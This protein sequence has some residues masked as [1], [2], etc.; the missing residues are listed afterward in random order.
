MAFPIIP[1]LNSAPGAGAPETLTLGELAANRSTAKLYLG[2]DTGVQEI[3]F[4]GS[5]GGTAISSF[6][7]AGGTSF[8]PINGYTSTNVNAY[9]VSVGG[10]EQRPTVDWTISATNGGT[11]VFATAPPTG[12][13]II[14]RAVVAGS[15]GGG[16][17]DIGGRA[18]SSTATYT[19]GDLVATSQTETWICIQAAN[20]N[21]NPATSPDWWAPAPASAVQLQF[22]PLAATAPTDG[23]A[24]VWDDANAT[25]APGT[26]SGGSSNAT[27]I[28]SRDIATTAPQSGEVL[29]WD[30]ATSKWTPKPI[31]ANHLFQH[32]IYWSD[33]QILA[34]GVTLFVSQA[35]YQP[36][37]NV[38]FVISRNAYSTSSSGVVVQIDSWLEDSSSLDNFVTV[39]GAVGLEREG[40]LKFVTFEGQAGY[41]S[42]TNAEFDLSTGDSTI[43]FW[44]YPQTNGYRQVLSSAGINFHLFTDSNLYINNSFD[45]DA[46]VPI[47][48]QSWNHIACVFSGSNKLVFVNG[49]LLSTTS[50]RFVGAQTL[51]IGGS[52]TTAFYGKI[53]GL[54]ICKQAVYTSDFTV[55]TTVLENISNTVLLLN[56]ASAAVPT[57]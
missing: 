33:Y 55:P 39:N 3:A 16:G 49:V 37:A 14:V 31:P 22:R 45:G 28:Q 44:M 46:S 23:Q 36:A 17:T 13:T 2:T 51:S 9:L 15:G 5:L 4:A 48:I 24:I 20:T 52:D 6:T 11:V 27:Q 26:V 50:Q 30:A 35:S 12:A 56:F 32:G 18:W 53:A 7:A 54:R 1:K 40:N 29:M 19:E 10:I 57:V 38:F 34:I 42:A 21:H 47:T 43:E 41:L 25:W 8:Y